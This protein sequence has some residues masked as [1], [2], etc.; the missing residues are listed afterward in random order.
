MQN[1]IKNINQE[2]AKIKEENNKNIMLLKNEFEKNINSVKEEITKMKNNNEEAKDNKKNQVRKRDFDLMK[3]D[4]Q[5]LNDKYNSFERVFENKLDFIESNLSKLLEEERKHKEEKKSENKSENKNEGNKNKININNNKINENNDKINE[6]NNNNI[7]NDKPNIWYNE[8]DEEIWK[9]FYHF[10]ETEFSEK[11]AKNK[12]IKKSDIEKFKKIS[13]NL[14][15]KGKLPEEKFSY[16]YKEKFENR[17]K[18]DLTNNFITKKSQIFEALIEIEDKLN[19]QKEKEKEK[20]KDKKEKKVDVKK[21]DINQFREEFNL[22]KK[23]FPDSLIKEKFV[24]CKGDKGLMLLK[25]TE[26]NK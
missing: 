21:F 15:K 7:I 22:S 24:Q 17:K 11:H 26:I 3:V 19:K 1:E 23:E 13:L 8:K 16:F 20:G 12:E 4:L 14:V 9:E 10:L 18:D 5:D 2:M 6:N 25:L